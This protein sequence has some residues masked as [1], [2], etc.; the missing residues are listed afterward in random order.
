M[1]FAAVSACV[2]AG[3][4][5]CLHKVISASDYTRWIGVISPFEIVQ[6]CDFGI[7]DK[8]NIPLKQRS[9]KFFAQIIVRM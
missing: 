6:L 9:K 4:K 8:Y 1:K 3:G 2:F 7:Y 5:L